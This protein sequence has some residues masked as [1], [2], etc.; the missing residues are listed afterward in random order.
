M[1]NSAYNDFPEIFDI[2]D[3]D[4]DAS[5]REYEIYLDTVYTGNNPLHDIPGTLFASPSRELNGDTELDDT[6]LEVQSL[7]SSFLED[8]ERF[9]SLQDSVD[10]STPHCHASY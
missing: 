4:M 7:S 1:S 9:G 2:P 5:F 3:H 6:L 8:A 10:N